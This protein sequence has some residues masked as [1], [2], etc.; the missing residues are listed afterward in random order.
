MQMILFFVQ[1]ILLLKRDVECSE[2]EN[3]DTKG[4]RAGIEKGSFLSQNASCS[5]LFITAARDQS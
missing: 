3:R 4:R 2:L 1:V 5:L